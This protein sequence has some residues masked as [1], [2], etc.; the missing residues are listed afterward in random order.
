[1]CETTAAMRRS[2]EIWETERESCVLWLLLGKSWVVW[3]PMW[4][5]INYSEETHKHTFTDE[6]HLLCRS[7]SLSH[8]QTKKIK[9]NSQTSVSIETDGCGRWTVNTKRGM[10]DQKIQ[11][12]LFMS[13]IAFCSFTI[14]KKKKTLY[15]H[16]QFIVKY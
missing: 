9:S 14:E 11:L 16:T 8:T 3:I 2:P 12:Y 10:L 6:H 7:C 4:I 13:L 5:A 15:T 1:M